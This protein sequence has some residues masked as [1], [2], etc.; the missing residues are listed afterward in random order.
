[1]RRQ[2][3]THGST[4]F[5]TSRYDE[6]SKFAYCG[7]QNI[8]QPSRGGEAGVFVQYNRDERDV[9]SPLILSRAVLLLLQRLQEVDFT[10]LAQVI[11]MWIQQLNP[12]VS[13]REL[14]H[15]LSV[16][17]SAAAVAPLFDVLN[18]DP[19]QRT[20]PVRELDERLAAYRPAVTSGSG[21]TKSAY[22]W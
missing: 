10:E 12:S 13:R 7:G 22:S 1:M 8:G 2:R 16:A 21:N 6:Q 3:F 9:L 5:S 14:L 15:K 11:V 17:F 4:R 20:K 18:P 19:W